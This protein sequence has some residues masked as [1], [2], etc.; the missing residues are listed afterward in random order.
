MIS[1][2]EWEVRAIS[3]FNSLSLMGISF[4][5][6]HVSTIAQIDENV[7]FPTIF[8]LYLTDSRNVF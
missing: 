6:S 2:E 3:I 5:I 7:L 4:L 1:E 8:S